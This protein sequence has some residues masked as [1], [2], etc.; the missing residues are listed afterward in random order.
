MSV[1]EYICTHLEF[2][3]MA[4]LAYTGK[5]RQFAWLTTV[6]EIKQTQNSHKLSAM[7]LKVFHLS[8]SK[9]CLG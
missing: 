8:S 3:P 7:E 2:D 6:Q 1:S 4:E 9:L 5:I